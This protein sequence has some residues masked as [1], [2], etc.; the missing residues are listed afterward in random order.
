MTPAAKPSIVLSILSEAFWINKLGYM[1][2]LPIRALY[3]VLR[4]F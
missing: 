1:G 4:L 2:V 3:R